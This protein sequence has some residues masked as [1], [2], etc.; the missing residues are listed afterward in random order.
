MQYGVIVMWE[1]LK[2]KF[3]ILF[4]KLIIVFIIFT[5]FKALKIGI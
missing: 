4:K 2:K 3:K 1:K 5:P